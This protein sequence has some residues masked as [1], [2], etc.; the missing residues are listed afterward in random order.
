MEKDEFKIESDSPWAILVAYL[1]ERGKKNEIDDIK[2]YLVLKEKRNKASSKGLSQK[3]QGRFDELKSEISELYFIKTDFEDYIDGD[4]S[5]SEEAKDFAKRIENLT[6]YVSDFNQSPDKSVNTALNR[7]ISANKRRRNDAAGLARQI[8]DG[9][10]FWQMPKDVPEH[11]PGLFMQFVQESLTGYSSKLSS[12]I[13]LANSAVNGQNRDWKKA[14]T[15]S[16]E[17]VGK[18][19]ENPNER[20]DLSL[21]D[22]TYVIGEHRGATSFRDSTTGYYA[23]IDAMVNGLNLAMPNQE[24]FRQEVDL[25]HNC[26]DPNYQNLSY[27]TKLSFVNAKHQL[28]LS[29]KDI[30]F[31]GAALGSVSS[32]MRGF[33]IDEIDDRFKQYLHNTADHSLRTCVTIASVRDAS[34]RRLEKIYGKKLAEASD[35][36]KSKFETEFQEIVKQTKDSSTYFARKACLHDMG[37]FLDEVLGNNLVGKTEE[38]E[39][40]LRALRDQLEERIQSHYAKL[41]IEHRLTKDTLGWKKDEVKEFIDLDKER[42]KLYD[43]KFYHTTFEIFERLNSN[44]DIVTLR[45]VGRINQ[46]GKWQNAKNVNSDQSRYTLQYVWSRVSGHKFKDIDPINIATYQDAEYKRKIEKDSDDASNQVA[47]ESGAAP[48]YN[49]QVTRKQDHPNTDLSLDDF[50]LQKDID[51][52]KSIFKNFVDSTI[53][54]YKNLPPKEA[55]AKQISNEEILYGVCYEMIHYTKKQGRM[56]PNFDDSKV[57][58]AVR[59]AV[60]QGID[61]AQADL[62]SNGLE[63]LSLQPAKTIKAEK[64]YPVGVIK[65]PREFS[66]SKKPE[67]IISLIN[68]D[69]VKMVASIFDGVYKLAND[70]I[71]KPIAT[72][73]VS[74]ALAHNQSITE[75]EFK[76]LFESVS[77]L[78]AGGDASLA[79]AGFMQTGSLINADARD[80]ALLNPIISATLAKPQRNREA[81]EKCYKYILSEFHGEIA[82]KY[83]IDEKVMDAILT[84]E[85][86]ESGRYSKKDSDITLSGKISENMYDYFANNYKKNNPQQNSDF[87]QAERYMLRKILRKETI[88]LENRLEQENNQA[89]TASYEEKISALTQAREAIAPIAITPIEVKETG[90][91]HGNGIMRTIGTIGAT[92]GAAA[93]AP[94]LDPSMIGDA[95]NIAAAFPQTLNQN[96]STIKGQIESHSDDVHDFRAEYALPIRFATISALGGVMMGSGVGGDISI[97]FTD[98]HLDSNIVYGGNLMLAGAAAFL[99]SVKDN[100]K[101]LEISNPVRK[102]VDSYPKAEIKNGHIYITK[103]VT[104][105]KIELPDDVEQE[106]KLSYQ[107]SQSNAQAFEQI[108]DATLALFGTPIRALA[109]QGAGIFTNQTTVSSWDSATTL[110]KNVATGDGLMQSAASMTATVLFARVG[111]LNMYMGEIYKAIKEGKTPD[112]ATIKK[113]ISVQLKE[114]GSTVLLNGIKNFTETDAGQ[115]LKSAIHNAILKPISHASELLPKVDDGSKWADTVKKREIEKL[116]EGRRLP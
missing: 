19:L 103:G 79:L 13:N 67:Q 37:E 49:P 83:G 107:L 61:A 74:M 82:Q 64:R 33:G 38:E 7:S 85:N 114:Q 60:S 76:Q 102:F 21:I 50:M 106:L 9:T 53:S 96:P 17:N 89:Q 109:T 46:D 24:K 34:I 42:D 57:E 88:K 4:K 14:Y 94:H 104:R 75:Q 35:V 73:P 90:K 111:V 68:P 92:V 43:N 80:A 87:E 30:D 84:R 28:R 95:L 10:K 31:Y 3:N 91:K 112:F 116:Q 32:I 22:L 101:Q 48:Q 39:K 113:K 36:D 2:E 15:K 51:Y 18:F 23:D 62:K 105:K 77:A 11:I 16:I 86:M 93:F 108:T 54:D 12:S 110:A 66:D 29:S 99:A 56:E 65:L 20:E 59:K 40:A 69:G 52:P 81:I 63:L 78:E 1:A 26:V 72:I 41:E 25:T 6:K 98:S 115:T 8:K 100:I 27:T 97:P 5:G 71:K 47:R 70:C 55:K 58:I 45:Q 44:H